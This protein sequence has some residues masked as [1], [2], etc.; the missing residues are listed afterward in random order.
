MKH[1]LP[2]CFLCEFPSLIIW[3][4]FVLLFCSCL[5]APDWLSLLSVIKNFTTGCDISTTVHHVNC[6]FFNSIQQFTPT[7]YDHRCN[8]SSLSVHC[9]WGFQ[10]LH[11]KSL[12][13]FNMKQIQGVLSLPVQ[14][15]GLV[16]NCCDIW[17]QTLSYFESCWQTFW[18]WAFSNPLLNCGVVTP[19]NADWLKHMS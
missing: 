8:I 9:H 10:M 3:S 14:N 18:P 6:D 16:Q 12:E 7:I 15:G 17:D 5:L 4:N 13:G 19:D 2:S 1:I 11:N